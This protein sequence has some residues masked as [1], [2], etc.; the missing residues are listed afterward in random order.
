MKNVHEYRPHAEECRK[1]AKVVTE[2]VGREQLLKMAEMWERLADDR[3]AALRLDHP[4][5]SQGT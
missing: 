3:E 1:L 4:E 2:S 5:A